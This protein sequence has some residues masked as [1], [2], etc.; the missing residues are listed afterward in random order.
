[1][2]IG[3]ESEQIEFVLS[4]AEKPQAAEAI[5]AILNKHAKGTLYFGIDDHGYVKGQ[6]ISDRTKRDI[7]RTLSEAIEP[8]FSFN[9][10]VLSIEGKDVIKVSFAGHNRPYSVEGRYLIRKGTENRRMSGEELKRLINNADYA[11][12]WELEMTDRRIEDIDKDALYDFYQSAISCGR[13]EEM[14]PYDEDKLLTMLELSQGGYLNNG[15]YALFGKDTEVGLKLTTYASGNKV[16]ILDLKLMTGNVYRLI[17][18]ALNYILSRISWRVE[19]R[20]R[21]R[22]EVPEIPKEAIREMVANAF[23]HADYETWPEIEIGIHP[24]SI[25]ISNPGTFPFEL[26]PYDFIRR[27]IPS[28]KRNKLMLD[29][30][31]RSKDV[32]KSGTGFQRMD[33]LCQE[34]GIRW[35]YRKDAIGFFFA[36]LR[37]GSEPEEIKE[38]GTE[39]KLTAIEEAVYRFIKSNLHLNKAELAKKSHKSIRTV[40]RAIAS[41]IENGYIR[42][43]GSNK[44]GY[45]EVIR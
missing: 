18:E 5:A 32:E 12:K 31:F 27:N 39:P 34:K 25:E 36:F 3:S 23:A 19:I 35:T 4:T 33:E 1:M 14:K 30:L 40:Q 15:G 11:S 44:T 28:Y 7:S 10:D 42:R 24:D 20:E 37:P 13:F 2:I 16:T 26:T 45:W 22:E 8:S 6:M 21:K 17:D 41:L 9:L 43:V 38:E 29:V